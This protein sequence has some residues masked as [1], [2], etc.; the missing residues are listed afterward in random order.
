[1]E[2]VVTRMICLTPPSREDLGKLLE[3]WRETPLSYSH[4]GGLEWP[5]ERGFIVDEYRV[6]LG[7]GA[8]LLHTS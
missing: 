8:S 7:H 2:E 4:R 6:C 5:P 1:M 3:S